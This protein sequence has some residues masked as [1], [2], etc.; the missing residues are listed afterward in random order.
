MLDDR[1]ADTARA[2]R[3]EW[4]LRTVGK[5][6]HESGTIKGFC[7]ECD[8]KWPCITRLEADHGLALNDGSV[9]SSDEGSSDA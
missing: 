9:A 3:L 6:H 5:L 7:N 8:Q 1:H 2:F 4:S